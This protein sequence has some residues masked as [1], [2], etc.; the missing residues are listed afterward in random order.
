MADR[1]A[2]FFCDDVMS[3]CALCCL[4]PATTLLEGGFLVAPSE[5]MLC[6]HL[7]YIFGSDSTMSWW[8]YWSFSFF[9]LKLKYVPSKSNGLLWAWEPKTISLLW[10][11]VP[12]ILLACAEVCACVFT[13]SLALPILWMQKILLFYQVNSLGPISGA[14]WIPST[15]NWQR[16]TKPVSRRISRTR[17]RPWWSEL[18][19]N[20]DP[21]PCATAAQSHAIYNIFN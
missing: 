18:F 17:K 4:G 13:H 7:C 15:A 21:S 6:I 9:C 10:Y 12:W 16:R 2:T 1:A 3:I 14:G 11:I 8:L 19:P 20:E 5:G